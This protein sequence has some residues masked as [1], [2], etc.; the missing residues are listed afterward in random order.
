VTV[1]DLR[2]SLFVCYDLRFA[3]EF[4][5]RALETDLYVVPANWPE[6]RREHWRVLLQARAIENQAYVLG[7]NRVGLAKTLPHSGDSVLI[8]PLGRRVAEAG[9]DEVVLGG[10]VSRA[11][12]SAIRAEFPF[13]V[14]RAPVRGT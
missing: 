7:V 6:P 3:D 9:A 5:A 2:V 4:W 11:T 13:L 8:D 12:V 10:E 14:D 1:D